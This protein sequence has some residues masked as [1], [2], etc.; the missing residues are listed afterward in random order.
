MSKK[1]KSSLAEALRENK[2]PS[3]TASAPQAGGTGDDKSVLFIRLDPDAKKQLEFLKIEQNA[4]S[5]T[6]LMSEA[7]NDLFLKYGKEPIA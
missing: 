3:V 4:P 7:I 6:A 1:N 2:K 5:I